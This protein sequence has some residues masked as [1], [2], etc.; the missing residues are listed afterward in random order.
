MVLGAVLNW[1]LSLWE[2]LVVTC[3]SGII[4]VAGPLIGNMFAGDSDGTKNLN[5][6]LGD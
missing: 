1:F 5:K 4:T 6:R 3:Y 2:G